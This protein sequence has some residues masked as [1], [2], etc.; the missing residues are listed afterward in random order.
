M[1]IIDEDRIAELN[2]DENT[3]KLTFLIEHYHREPKITRYVTA[4]YNRTPIYEDYSERTRVVKKYDKIINPIRFV[5]EQIKELNLE[6][7][8]VN[9]IIDKIGIIPDW[10]KK[11]ME[12]EENALHIKKLEKNYRDFSR[13]KSQY[14]YKDLDLPEFPS[15]FWLR[16]LF[17]IPTLGL[18]FT[19]YVSKKK[20]QE[21]IIINNKNAAWNIQHKKNIDQH[22]KALHQEINLHNNNNEKELQKAKEKHVEISTR[23]IKL[24]EE[25]ENGWINLREAINFS[26]NDL[27]GVKGVYII[28]NKTMN[29][30]YVGQSKNLNNRLFKQHF[31]NG[32]VKNHIFFKDWDSGNDFYYRT[33]VCETKDELDRLEKRYIE[34]YNSFDNGYNKTGGNR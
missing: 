34:E 3:H 18:S 4:N 31:G 8:L 20:A 23:K 7:S 16:L 29:K 21:N 30:Y 26:H 33:F 2:Y 9:K 1:D 17:A 11:E 5:N 6:K 10:R 15:N 14:D 25:D 24:Y 32:L 22:N 19:R 13:E 12:I 27:E 28:W